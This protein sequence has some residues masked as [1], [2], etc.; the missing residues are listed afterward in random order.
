[1]IKFFMKINKVKLKYKKIKNRTYFWHKSI[2]IKRKEY[3]G[4]ICFL[5]EKAEKQKN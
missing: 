1:M 5:R 3:S 4:F 2:Q